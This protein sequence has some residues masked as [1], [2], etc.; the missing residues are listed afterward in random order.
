MLVLIPKPSFELKLSC[1]KWLNQYLYF[2]YSCF[3]Q[4]KVVFGPVVVINVREI[5]MSSDI[6]RTSKLQPKER[7]FEGGM[8]FFAKPL[9]RVK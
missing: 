6:S 8:S 3:W 7:H 5:H 9:S 1:S 2:G 4:L